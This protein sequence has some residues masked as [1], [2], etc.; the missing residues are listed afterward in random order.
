MSTIKKIWKNIH[1][2]SSLD[3]IIY[4]YLRG[5]PL[6]RGFTKITNSNKLANGAFA[7]QAFKSAFWEF[8]NRKVDNSLWRYQ[9]WQKAWSRWM[10]A[11]GEVL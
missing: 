7:D 1:D 11:F 4:N 10:D 3:H 6:D 2:P 5:L 8:E 9:R